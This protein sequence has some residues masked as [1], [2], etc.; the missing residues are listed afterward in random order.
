[1]VVNFYIIYSH[2][3]KFFIC[4]EI[5]F[6][7]LYKDKYRDNTRVTQADFMHDENVEGLN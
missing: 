4:N 6:S 7:Y 3:Q 2:V 5:T 1:M